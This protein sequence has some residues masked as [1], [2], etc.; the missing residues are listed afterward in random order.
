MTTGRI[1]QVTDGRTDRLFFLSSKEEKNEQPSGSQTLSRA[2]S[3]F[4]PRRKKRANPEGVHGEKCPKKQLI[5]KASESR[6]PSNKAMLLTKRSQ[7]DSRAN[8][9][10]FLFFF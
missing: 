1:N 9:L 7:S 8:S 6:S 3:S 10:A 5:I 4:L 2:L